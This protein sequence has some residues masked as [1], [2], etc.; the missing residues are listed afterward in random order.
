MQ[1]REALTGRLTEKEL[2]ILRASY[3]TVGTIAILEISPLLKKKETLIAQALLDTNSHIKTVVKKKSIRSGKLRLQDYTHLLG[4]KTTKT[5]H[6]ESGLEFLLDIKDVYFSVRLS[7]ERLRVAQQ[8]KKG[9]LVLVLFSGC[10]PYPCVFAKHSPAKMIYGIELNKEGHWYGRENVVRNRIQNVFLMQGDVKKILPEITRHL[11]GLKCSLNSSEFN[12]VMKQK[13]SLVELY[14]TFEECMSPVLLEK[15]IKT[16]ITY[17]IEPV[18]HAPWNENGES[19]SLAADGTR[20]ARNLHLYFTLGKLAKKYNMKVIIHAAHE[21]EER[22]DHRKRMLENVPK[23]HDYFRWFYFENI[24][25]SCSK[26]LT[27]LQQLIGCGIKN[28][29]FDTCHLY[30]DFKDNK[31]MLKTVEELFNLPVNLYFHLA[32]SDGRI[33][34]MEI[35]KGKVDFKQI[36]PFLTSG[37]AEI[38]CKNYKK[39]GEMI[40]SRNLLGAYPKKFDRILMPLPKSAES[41]LGIT[42]QAIKPGG[43][44]HFYDFAHES[45]MPKSSIAKI[46]KAC[47]QE[48]K[49]YQILSWNVCGTYAPGKHRVCVD[50]RVLN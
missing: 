50:I 8:I 30:E 27:D 47:A 49:K 4:E 34:A 39:P 12:T 25:R 15:R 36:V 46:G 41:F 26:S 9:E 28:V 44:I 11:T 32:D 21:H 23:L 42:L 45:E 3:D 13:P 38:D 1:L 18:V 20:L 16:L 7:S 33:H 37:I 40:R 43:I 19:T 6:K 5:V 10:A 17:S 48:K 31:L 22:S 2:G 24:V 14:V 35:G 29:C